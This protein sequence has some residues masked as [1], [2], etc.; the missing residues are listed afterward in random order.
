MILITLA[1][2]AIAACLYFTFIAVPR[3]LILASVGTIQFVIGEVRYI[4]SLRAAR[5]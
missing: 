2:A 3:M 5:R 4:R 1:L